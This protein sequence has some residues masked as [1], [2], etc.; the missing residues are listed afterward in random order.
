ML[1]VSRYIR[2]LSLCGL[3]SDVITVLELGTVS[4]PSVR[5]RIQCSVSLV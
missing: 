1:Q 3:S 5:L 2:F 4:G